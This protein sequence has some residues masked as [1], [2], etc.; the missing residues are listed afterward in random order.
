[1]KDVDYGDEDGV[2]FSPGGYQRVAEIIY[3]ELKPLLLSKL[4]WLQS[5]ESSL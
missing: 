1:M 2:H 3:R 5:T 4:P